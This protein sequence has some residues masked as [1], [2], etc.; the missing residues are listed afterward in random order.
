MLRPGPPPPGRARVCSYGM[1]KAVAM[2][3]RRDHASR[4]VTFPTMKMPIELSVVRHGVVTVCGVRVIPRGLQK[5]FW[6]QHIDRGIFYG[7]RPGTSVITIFG[8][9]LHTIRNLCAFGD[10]GRV[11]IHKRI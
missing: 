8:E 3:A 4:E 1:A 10:T 6:Q 7:R 11:G 5:G 9:K 2:R